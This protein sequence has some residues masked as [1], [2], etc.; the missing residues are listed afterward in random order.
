MAAGIAG[1][2]GPPAAEEQRRGVDNVTTRHP[3]K[4][5]WTAEDCSKSPLNAKS[6]LSSPDLKIF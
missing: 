1:V 6:L 5:A 2:H 3:A 4:G